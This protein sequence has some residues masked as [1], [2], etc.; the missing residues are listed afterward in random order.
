MLL[1]YMQKWCFMLDNIHKL[2]S[3]E[4]SKKHTLMNG[5]W[6]AYAYVCGFATK[7]SL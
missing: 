3:T 1:I 6:I 7:K 2:H 5:Q 4:E